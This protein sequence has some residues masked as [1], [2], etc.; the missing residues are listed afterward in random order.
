MNREKKWRENAHSL[1]STTTT[2]TTTTVGRPD[3]RRRDADRAKS[4]DEW[5][6]ESGFETVGAAKRVEQ[7]AGC[8]RRVERATDVELLGLRVGFF[9]VDHGGAGT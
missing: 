5:V 3:D 7:G 9:V 4:R 2:T 1:H 8:G 6:G